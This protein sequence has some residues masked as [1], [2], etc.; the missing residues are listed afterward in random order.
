MVFILNYIDNKPDLNESKLV[1]KNYP[2]VNS[3]YLYDSH[4]HP[5]YYDNELVYQFGE[6]ES[7]KWYNPLLK[8][9]LELVRDF[10][11]NVDTA[12]NLGCSTGRLVFDLTKTFQEV[13]L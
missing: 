11:V 6:A 13:S 2:T 3:Q 5:E 8:K 9:T 4:N 12:T 7:A 10:K 1:L